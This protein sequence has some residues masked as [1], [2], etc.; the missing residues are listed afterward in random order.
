MNLTLFVQDILELPFSQDIL[1]FP[2]CFK[3]TNNSDGNQT[4]PDIL[5]KKLPKSCL[6]QV[7]ELEIKLQDESI[8]KKESSSK[9]SKDFVSA[10]SKRF[11]KYDA[12]HI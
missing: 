10:I 12:K 5:N 7:M 4:E 3:K 6:G 8:I 2:F 9:S 1:K 11:S